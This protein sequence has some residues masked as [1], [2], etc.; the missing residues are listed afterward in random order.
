MGDGTRTVHAQHNLETSLERAKK[1]F[2]GSMPSE[3]ERATGFGGGNSKRLIATFA[4]IP[5]SMVGC[6]FPALLAG[7]FPRRSASS[8]SRNSR[9]A[10]VPQHR[11]N[12]SIWARICF[13]ILRA[14]TEVGTLET[15]SYTECRCALIS[16]RRRSRSWR[17]KTRNQRGWARHGGRKLSENSGSE[18]RRAMAGDTLARSCP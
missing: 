17:S 14:S 9:T 3:A 7:S 12:E 10:I 4:S 11:R 18:M 16:R 13:W 8:R 5:T 6:G 1:H 2:V 15:V